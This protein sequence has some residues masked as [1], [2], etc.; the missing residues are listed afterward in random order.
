MFRSITV[1]FLVWVA[2]DAAAHTPGACDEV[3]AKAQRL[4]CYDALYPIKEPLQTSSK[5]S[6]EEDLAKEISA[7]VS[8][9]APTPTQVPAQVQVPAPTPAQIKSESTSEPVKAA[10]S[11]PAAEPILSAEDRFGREQVEKTKSEKRQELTSIDSKITSIKKRASQEMVFYLENGQVWLQVTA[12][13]RSIKEGAEVT[14][15][16]ARLGGYVLTAE[17]GVST[18]VKRLR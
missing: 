2:T 6:S 1:L 5:A 4:A 14:I 9:V 13:Y 18:R 3:H 16:K 11:Q 8:S 12:R 17:N 10:P 7:E 15:N